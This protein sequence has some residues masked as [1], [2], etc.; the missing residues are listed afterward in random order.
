LFEGGLIVTLT[1][2]GT[3]LDGWSIGVTLHQRVVNHEVLF[4]SAVPVLF[5]GTRRDDVTGS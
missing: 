2:V 5:A 3:P 1:D 4:V